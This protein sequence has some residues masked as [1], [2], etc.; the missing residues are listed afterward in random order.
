MKAVGIKNLK[1]NLSKYLDLVREGEIVYVTDRDDIIAEIHKPISAPAAILSPW[2]AFLNEEERKGSL[3][4]AKHTGPS[5][6]RQAASG[7]APP[8]LPGWKKILDES[9]EDRF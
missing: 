3:V 1:N 2:E 7:S 8:A 4:R 9:R 5:R 6:I